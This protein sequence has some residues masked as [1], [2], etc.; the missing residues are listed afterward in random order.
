MKKAKLNDGTEVYCLLRPEAI[1]LD[2]HVEG[3]LAHGITVK[4]DSVIFDVGANIGVMGV[5]MVQRY[6]QAQVYSFEPIPPIYEVLKANAQ[7]HGA[8]R[9]HTFNCGVGAGPGRLKFTYYPN[10]PA[11]STSNPE[12]WDKDPEALVR[13]VKGSTQHA[14]PQLRWTRFLPGFIHRIVA[15]RMRTGGI[16]VDCPLRTISDV[17]AEQKV[18]RIDLL[19]IDCE[20]AEW[21]VLMGIAPTDWPKVQQVV[22]EVH[23]TNGRADQ[24]KA[25]LKTHGFIKIVGEK[26]KA[27]EGTELIN[28]YAIR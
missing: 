5:R 27:L 25:L 23:D 13:A 8:G 28:L 9:F 18:D 14:P 26:E 19:K 7:R 4:A 20:G 6:P 16:Q 22:V 21:D 11:L 3:Y 2:Y 17:V 10:S 15:K 12:Q 1:V 24:V